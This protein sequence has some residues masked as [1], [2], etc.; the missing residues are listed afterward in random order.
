[1]SLCLT[2]PAACDREERRFRELPPAATAAPAVTLNDAVQAGPTIHDPEI[3]S[4]YDNNAYAVAEG[5]QLYDQMNC[6]SCHSPRGG[7]NMGPSLIDSLWVYGSEPENIHQT[8]VQGRPNGMP[9]Y[10]ERLSND[11]VWKLVAYVRQLATLTSPNVRAGRADEMHLTGPDPQ[12]DR[13]APMAERIPPEQLAPNSPPDVRESRASQ[14][15]A[16]RDTVT[17]RS[18]TSRAGKP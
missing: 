17:N 8:I 4:V 18:D 5:K 1:M 12:T 15:S 11:Q 16:W 10:R 9:A 13:M 14:D 2:T 7:G 6:A 3:V